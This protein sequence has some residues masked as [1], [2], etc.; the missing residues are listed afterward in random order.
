MK[1]LVKSKF[2]TGIVSVEDINLLHF[3][4]NP[5]NKPKKELPLWRFITLK[6]GSERKANQ[7]YY[8]TIHMLIVEF[9]HGVRIPEI[10]QLASEYSYALHTTS[11]H[12]QEEHRFRLMLPLDISYPE[13][14]WRL[15]LVKQAMQIKFPGL[16]KSCFI[17]YQCIPALPANPSDYYYKIQGGRKFGYNEIAEIVLRLEFDEEMERKFLEASK[18]KR[19]YLEGEDTH[20]DRYK[21][22]VDDSSDRLIASLPSHENGT[23]YHD[24][25]SVIGKLLNCKYP[26]GEF[27]YDPEDIKM[28]LRTVYWDNAIEKAWRSFSRKR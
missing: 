23:R 17:N 1:C 22:K 2:E 19:V 13:S 6:E 8:D 9:D 16:D 27:I 12:T 24:F 26:D 10:E 20:F 4:K 5:S 18:P 28:M 15:P 7:E 11:N 14:F 21:E 25:C 3:I